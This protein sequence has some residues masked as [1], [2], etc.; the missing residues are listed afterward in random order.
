MSNAFKGPLDRVLD[1]AQKDAQG[2]WVFQGARSSGG[3]GFVRV[4]GKNL[5]THRVVY[6]SM[7]GDIPE[8]LHLDHLC[9]NRACVNPEHLEAVTPQVNT[10][11]GT[12]IQAQNAAKTHCHRGHEFSGPNLRIDPTGRRIC[13]TCKRDSTRKLRSAE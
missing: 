6:Q 12:S 1:R 10:L 9:R 5:Y 3:Y 7:V 13:R 8:G 4:S 2:C 11:R